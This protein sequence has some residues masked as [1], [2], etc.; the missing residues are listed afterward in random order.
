MPGC[1]CLQHNTR[2]SVTD[3]AAAHAGW[4]PRSWCIE[5]SAR[6]KLLTKSQAMLS[7]SMG[8]GSI[9]SALSA[10]PAY[11]LYSAVAAVELQPQA[12]GKATHPSSILQGREHKVR[13]G[14]YS[15][16]MWCKHT[17][18]AEAVLSEKKCLPCPGQ[19]TL[20]SVNIVKWTS[21][22]AR[23]DLWLIL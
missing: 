4:C 16:H 12:V 1:T 8:Q 6:H 17:Y 19:K 5:R 2:D 3:N 15:M 9:M 10:L 21:D 14:G 22:T 20:V 18:H 23:P 13:A 11:L 7:L